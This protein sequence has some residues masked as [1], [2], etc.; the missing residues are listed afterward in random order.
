MNNSANVDRAVNIAALASRDFD[1]LVIGGGITGAGVA[2]DAALRGLSV[3]LVER[4]DFASGTSSR[5]SRLIHGGLRYLEHGY[6]H[7][8][9]ESSAERRRLLELAPHLVH[10]LAFTWPVYRGARAGR[11]KLA[12]GLMLYELLALWRNVRRHRRLD[13]EGVAEREPA[14]RREGLTGGAVYY[15]AAT[16][17]ARLTLANVLGAAAAGAVIANHC[18]VRALTIE[19]GR[20]TGASVTN[21][22]DGG[23]IDV[24]ARVIVNAAG[25]WTDSIRRM[26]E[27]NAPTT[28]RGTKGAHIAVPRDRVGNRDA[29]TLLSPIDGRVMFILPAGERTIV[30]T[31]DTETGASPDEVRATTADVDYLLRSANAFFPDARLERSDVVSAWAGIRPLIA[32]GFGDGPSSAS[33]EH[34]IAHTPAG[35]VA[36]TGGKLTTY[37]VM[38]A[39]IVD[40]V[41]KALDRGQVDCR[42][43]ELPLPGGDIESVEGEIER[44]IA[45]SGDAA[46]ARHLVRRYGSEWTDVWRMAASDAALRTPVVDEL[47]DL[48]AELRYGAEREMACTLADLLIRR[49]HIA[50]AT[51]DNGR[52]AAV[53]A[54]TVVAPVFGWSEAGVRAQLMDYER[55]VARIFAIGDV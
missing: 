49:T 31:T 37:R 17:D 26:E 40:V 18:E 45:E 11:W 7:L 1:V 33:R 48:C 15:D 25:P 4:D 3:A 21:L 24:R 6:L 23:R 35:V 5:S 53:V 51:R 34:A 10:P 22:L 41:L 32:G 29:L 38:A 27:P 52:G 14:L 44:A 28:V 16:D 20:A 54:A 50:F 42:T 39:E 2:R 13:A 43:G 46:V 30:G 36:I 47:P 55:E 19:N 12:A 8:V 9:F